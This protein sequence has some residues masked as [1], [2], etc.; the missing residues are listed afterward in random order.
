MEGDTFLVD[1]VHGLVYCPVP[2]VGC[3]FWK[4]VFAIL[5][6]KHKSSYLFNLSSV[7]IHNTRAAYDGLK[8]KPLLM[9]YFLL[10]SSTKF[11]FVRDPYERLFSGYIDKIFTPNALGGRLSQ[12]ISP[13]S[14]HQTSCA[15]DA[16]FTEFLR[17]VTHSN[18][19]NQHF[20]PA[21]STCFPCHMDYDVIGKMETFRQDTESILKSAGVDP[22]SVFGSVSSFDENS[23]LSIMRD[24]AARTFQCLPRC[25]GC[26]SK[27]Q[28]MRR[29]W[30]TFQVRGYLSINVT[31]PLSPVKSEKVTLSQVQDLL[32]DA[33]RS[34]GDHS[35][36][37]RQ[38]K[39]AMMETYYSVPRTVLKELEAYVRV[40]CALFGYDCSVESRFNESSR[41]V[42]VFH[43]DTLL[44][45]VQSNTT[46]PKPRAKTI[47]AINYD[48]RHLQ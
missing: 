35:V 15:T 30:A 39:A 11:M 19:V 5:D 26:M 7:S 24:V 48:R 23:D 47:A 4:R 46:K 45:R 14:D 20:K 9:K 8:Q 34:S 37:K 42:P 31:F 41:P 25:G 12:Q 40:D 17:Y 36:T 10:Q 22:R 32:K 44:G 38:R 1:D 2:K 29:M 43:L 6:G 27:W 21:Y 33:Y 3:S 18:S 16:T 28:V 13:N